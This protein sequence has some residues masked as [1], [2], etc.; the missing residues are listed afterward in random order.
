MLKLTL[1]ALL[2][3]AASAVPAP[4]LCKVVV[5]RDYTFAVGYYAV[6]TL[7]PGC[8]AHST[9][10][11]RKSSTLNL[12]EQGAAYQPIKLQSGAW[13]VTANGDDVPRSERT[14]YFFST[15]EWQTYDGHHWLPAEVR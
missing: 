7:A 14:V 15:W 11:L 1:A 10:R 13:N 3:G 12:K 9:G 5:Y 4:P 2:L 8:P 6:P